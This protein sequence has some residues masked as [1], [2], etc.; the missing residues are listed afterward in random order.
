MSQQVPHTYYTH[1]LATIYYVKWKS[2]SV[3]VVVQ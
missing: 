2:Y 1:R 3:A